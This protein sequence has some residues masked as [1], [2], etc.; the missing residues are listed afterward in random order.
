MKMKNSETFNKRVKKIKSLCNSYH[1]LENPKSL[2][3]KSNR[4]EL[5]KKRLTRALLIRK[6]A[7]KISKKIGMI[8]QKNHQKRINVIEEILKDDKKILEEFD[9]NLSVKNQ[10]NQEEIKKKSKQTKQITE[11]TKLF[12]SNL[13]KNTTHTDLRTFFKGTKYARIFLN[14]KMESK[15]CGFVEFKNEQYANEALKLT[16]SLL[17][18]NSIVCE[19]NKK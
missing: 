11:K 5:Y 6:K 3:K 17:N 1:A 4:V 10:E 8:I 16:G 19:F 14:E 13:S 2:I 7:L 12:I 15:R 9:K 18:G